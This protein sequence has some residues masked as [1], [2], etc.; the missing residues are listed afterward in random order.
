MDKPDNV[1]WPRPHWR[2]SGRDALVLYFV[3]GELGDMPAIPGEHYRTRGLPAGVQVLQQK[4]AKLAPWPGYPLSGE[5]GS[6]LLSDQPALVEQARRADNVLMLR[7]TLPDPRDLD[8]LRDVTG[9]LTALLDRGA[10]AVVDPLTLSIFDA[11][12]WQAQ[13]R[14]D[15]RFEVR[16]HV[17]IMSDADTEPG[18]IRVHTRGM[19]RFA[20]P[21]IAIRQ[22]P[23]AAAAAIGQL[24]EELAAHQA[25]GGVIAEGHR[26]EIE[27]LGRPL[28]AHHL[29]DAPQR[30]DNA[31]VEF[32]W[33]ATDG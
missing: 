12:S 30:F 2:S 29:A 23:A 16:R 33:P 14:H 22:V 13:H 32:V 6:A 15:D 5:L 19:A 9:V 17:L 31:R 28:H 8:Y 21:D 7:G 3:F 11:A 18:T 1:I 27:P 10:C 4:N 25:L 24:A 26:I 20:R